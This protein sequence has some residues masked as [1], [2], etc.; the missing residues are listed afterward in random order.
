MVGF[1]AEQVILV[2]D[3]SARKEILEQIGKQ[4]LVLTIV[5]CKG[6]EFQDVLLYNFFGTSPLKNQWRVVYGY[7]KQQNLF[8]SVEQKFPNFSKAKHKLLCSE[9]K[10]L[11]VAITRTRQR[12]W[13]CENVDEF[14]KPMYEYWKEKSL[15]QVRELDESLAQ[16]M[17]VASSKEEWLSRGIK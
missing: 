11:Y 8:S 5:E 7:M 9:L 15:V 12:L 3:E 16:A 2:R 6:L 4:A 17:K 14:S 1:G 13:I 10:Q